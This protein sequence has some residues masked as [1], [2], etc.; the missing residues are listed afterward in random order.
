MIWGPRIVSSKCNDSVFEGTENYID[1]LLTEFMFQ[2][3]QKGHDRLWPG[4]P[5]ISHHTSWQ[6]PATRKN[7]GDTDSEW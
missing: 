2:W 6:F 1:L 7:V 4:L 5:S 3:I